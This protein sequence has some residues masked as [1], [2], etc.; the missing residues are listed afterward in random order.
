MLHNA[1]IIVLKELEYA[2]AA[3]R[4]GIPISVTIKDIV[5]DRMIAEHLIVQREKTIYI[6]EL[7][8]KFLKM[9]TE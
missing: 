7:G 8:I 6:T 2:G 1:Y 5:I 9:A 3:L 4:R